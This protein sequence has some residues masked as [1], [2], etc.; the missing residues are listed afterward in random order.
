VLG[1]VL[2]WTLFAFGGLYPSTL[3]VPA[4][5]V[6]AL[7]VAYRPAI[8]ARGPSPALDRLLLVTLGA[9]LLQLVPLPRTV[10]NWMSPASESVMRTLR[11]ADT[12]GAL[13]LSIDLQDS[14]AATLLYAAVLL[15]FFAARQIFDAGGVRTTTRAIAVMGLVVSAVAVAQD[16]TGGGLMYWR[17]RPIDDGPFPFGPFVNR[18]HFGTWAIMAVPLCA[19]YLTAH[20]SAHHGPGAHASW[21]RRAVAALD[22]RAALL[23]ASATLLIVAV[24]VSLSRSAIVGLSAALILGGE[25]ARRRAP[26][27]VARGARPAVLAAV[28][29][30][31]ALFGVATRV[32]PSA[33]ASRFARADTAIADRVTIWRDAVPV[34]KDFW[35]TGTGVGTYQTAMALYQRSSPG[36]LFNQAH[37]HFLQIAAEGGVLVALP[38]FCALGVFG[39]A[40]WRRLREDQ[41][42][43][44]WLRAG[45]AAGLCGVAVQSLW[46][47]GLTLPANA[48]LA[49][50][51]AAI[52][53]HVP[54]RYGPPG[55][56]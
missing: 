1:G 6:L 28:L 37:N 13:P 56:R 11:L 24:A 55:V 29:L 18:N 48:A 16:A 15:L 43:V 50:V 42:A 51:L 38:A 17:W 3:A 7:G 12:G 23:L 27:I 36:V 35:L 39:R 30:C 14:A 46:E 45:A 33:I 21:R 25:L 22:G 2:A 41:S 5:A 4:M 54:G 10:L 34:L 53:L 52:V 40:G 44:Y 8:V 19:G 32:G 26:G 20:A 31:L 47:T 9:A 49:A